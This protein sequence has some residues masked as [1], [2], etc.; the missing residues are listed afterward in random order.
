M[1]RLSVLL[2]LTVSVAWLGGTGTRFERVATCAARAAGA[3]GE[4]NQHWGCYENQC[5]EI[6]ECGVDDCSAC[7]GCDPNQEYQCVAEGRIWDP[8]T[9]TCHD[10]ICDPWVEQDCVNAWGTWDP[11]TCTCSN[12]CNPQPA[13]ELGCDERQ[14]VWWCWA[15]YLGEVNHITS[16]Y[17]EQ[18]CEDGRLWDSYSL[19]DGYLW[20][21]WTEECWWMC[22]YE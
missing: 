20:P 19:E 5:V 22:F 17:Y 8:E 14:E 18:Y 1:R 13:V 6:Y 11:S 4:T 15:C 9:C 21:E 10:P 2:A 12:T 3:G 7:Q 16:C